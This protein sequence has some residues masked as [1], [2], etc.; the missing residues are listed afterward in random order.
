[1]DSAEP[2]PH[3]GFRVPAYSQFLDVKSP[4]W[5]HRACGIVAVKS[6]IE[7]FLGEEKNVPN[8]DDLIKIGLSLDAYQPGK[9]WRHDG[10]VDIARRYNLQGA[11]RDY[12]HLPE[13]KAFAIL[14]QVLRRRP[15]IVSIFK[16]F[17][18]TNG[19]HLIVVTRITNKH[20]YYNDPAAKTRKHVRRKRPI[21]HFLRGWRKRLI[22][23]R[24]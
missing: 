9:G 12:A 22:D 16:D 3:Q 7:Y 4:G 2:L 10:L 11:A 14:E 19:G 1:M 5:S 23:T 21:K 18:P 24:K 13:S 8:I 15:C 20:V 17:N 6:I